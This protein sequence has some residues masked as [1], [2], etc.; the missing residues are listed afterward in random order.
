MIR[1][2]PLATPHGK[3]KEIFEDVFLVTGSVVMAPGIQLSRN[4]I[5]IREDTS[6]TLIS[7]VRLDDKGLQALEALGD[8]KHVVKLGAYHLGDNN[9]IDDPFYLNRYN[10]KLWAMPEMKHSTGLSTTNFLTVGAELPFKDA[11]LFSYETSKKPEGLLLINR[12]GGIL[13]SGDSLQNWLEPDEYFSEVA[14]TAMKKFG[15]FR[16]A[17]IGPKWLRACEAKASDFSQVLE[18]EF[19]H[20]LPSH[21]RP[22]IATAKQEFSATISELF[23]L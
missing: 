2:Y 12:A 4:M 22:I 9:G 18:L 17:N 19:S 6:L 3:I 5:I 13:I 10:A 15:F 23:K 20:L 14:A 16:A 1:E 11:L 21:G 8:V 7:T